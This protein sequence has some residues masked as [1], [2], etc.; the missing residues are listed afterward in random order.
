VIA[1]YIG[2]AKKLQKGGY[3]MK[4]K[5]KIVNIRMDEKDLQ[6]LKKKASTMRVSVSDYIR[7]KTLA[8]K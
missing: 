7:I 5:K 4:K 2:I 6:T 1:I 3:T 8:E